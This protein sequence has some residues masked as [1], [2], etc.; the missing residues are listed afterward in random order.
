MDRKCEFGVETLPGASGPGS[1]TVAMAI[2]QK[3]LISQL[4]LGVIK[5]HICRFLLLNVTTQ[6]TNV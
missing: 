3:Q 1:V 6:V 4:L 2:K 5:Q